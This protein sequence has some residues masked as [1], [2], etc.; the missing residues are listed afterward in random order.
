VK[1]R[2]GRHESLVA[3]LA[4]IIARK[5]A[6]GRERDKAVLPVLERTLREK[7]AS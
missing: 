2:L 6:A 7:T 1:V 3:G 5:R 4:D